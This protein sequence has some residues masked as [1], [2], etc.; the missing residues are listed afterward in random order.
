M[1]F[2]R[3]KTDKPQTKP[4]T[5]QTTPKQKRGGTPLS[6]APDSPENIPNGDITN[7]GTG[8]PTTSSTHGENGGARPKQLLPRSA[9]YQDCQTGDLGHVSSLPFDDVMK[10]KSRLSK[11]LHE[12]LHD[13]DALAYFIQYMNSRGGG[14]LIK[15]WLD[16]ESFQASTWTRIRS[17]S[18]NSLSKSAVASRSRS[19]T[20]SENSQGSPENPTNQSCSSVPN[21]PAQDPGSTSVSHS[22]NAAPPGSLSSVPVEGQLSNNNSVNGEPK[23]GDNIQ[24]NSSVVFLD[25]INEDFLGEKLRKSI[26]KDA[27]N[28]Y[29]R[30][31][32]L[33]A[34]QPI[35][36]DEEM[37]NATISKICRED[38]Q[39][40]A[41]CFVACQDH[42]CLVMDKDY[43]PDF[44]RSDFH[45]KHQIDVL[46]SGKVYL[47]DILYNDTAMFYFMEYMETEGAI[48]LLQFLM[49][50]DNFQEHL[51]AQNGRY[52]GMQAQEDAMVLYEKYFSLQAS[53]PLGFD[54][55]VR[56]EVESNICREGGPLPDCF[57][58]PRG[59]V[60]T[61]INKHYFPPFI[62][63]ELYYKYLSELINTLQ[64]SDVPNPRKKRSGS[65]ASSEHSIGAHSSGSSIEPVSAKNTLLAI[66]STDPFSKTLSKLGDDLRIDTLLLTNPENLYL[67]PNSGNM[68]LGRV[69]DIGRF[70]SEFDPEPEKDKKKGASFFT[71]KKQ[72]KD[73]A[74]EAMAWQIAQMIINDV[75]HM[76]NSVTE[77]HS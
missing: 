28:I 16:A 9:S 5:P 11:T 59:I 48:T 68:S 17:H 36:I 33:D 35:G 51:S 56:F 10:T 26:E 61:H 22:D 64:T 72:D 53:S 18:M 58:R 73:K 77:D 55:K 76:T 27:V 24:S 40:D 1:P 46:T 71:K 29:S 52:D 34:T 6:L 3:R 62:Q 69:D 2:F 44:L 60:L 31:I 7:T 70:V 21:V 25:L 14:H 30:Y 43:F 8:L 57:H 45:C 39:V 41:H 50:V 63:S 66:D 13:R 42:V 32:S 75:N 74:Q 65:D 49:V 15:F 19:N 12:V 67:R 20:S 37:R 38:G 4:P 54:D 47:P 23:S